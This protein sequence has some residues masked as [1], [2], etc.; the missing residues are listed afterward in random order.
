MIALDQSYN[1]KSQAQ[2]TRQA[3]EYH[4]DVA[5]G[6]VKKTTL[7]NKFGYNYDIDIGTETIWSA[8]GLLVPLVS[9]STLSIVST[10]AQDAS[11][12]TGA[13]SIIIYGIDSTRTAVTQLVQLTGLTPVVTATTWLGINRM[14]VYLS[15]TSQS[16][17]GTINATAVSTSNIQAQ[18]PA[19]EGTTQ[20]AF[21]FSQANHTLLLEFLKLNATKI[22][23]GNQPVVT[24]KGWVTS[25]LTNSR[26]EIFRH[27]MDTAIENTVIITPPIPFV[28]GPVSIITFEA[29]TD[30]ND[31]AVSCRFSLIEI[32]DII[33]LNV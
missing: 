20:Q 1:N 33:P 30:K 12:G 28:I 32:A 31:T 4:H 25:F 16:N 21:L 2:L 13:S 19:G 23:A 14:A 17:V 11:G 24:I 27:I 15:G 26:Y 6:L 8:G 3:A 5:R 22:A 18:I 7:W 9:P 29:T 10:S